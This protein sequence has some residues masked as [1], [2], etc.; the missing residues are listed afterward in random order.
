MK[1][2]FSFAWY[3]D[4]HQLLGSRDGDYELIE[5]MGYRVKPCLIYVYEAEN[6]AP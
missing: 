2:K 5:S 3:V 1:P 6:I 4:T